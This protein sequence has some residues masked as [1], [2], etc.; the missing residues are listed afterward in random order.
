MVRVT[1]DCPL[2]DPEIIDQVIG[3]LHAH[4]DL[5]YVSNVMERSYP[6]GLDCEALPFRV[7]DMAFKE[8]L[9]IPEREHVTPFIYSRPE[10]FKLAG[11]RNSEDLSRHRWTVDTLDDFRLIRNMLEALYPEK[12]SFLLKDCI[13][14]LAAHP[15]WPAINAEIEQKKTFN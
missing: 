15:D 14:L 11:I 7:L 13:A 6:R 12:P 8:A 2:I 5:D 10:R 3:H 4:P 1:S 9:S